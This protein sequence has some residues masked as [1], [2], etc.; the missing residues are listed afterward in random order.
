M[1]KLTRAQSVAA[2]MFKKQLD[3]IER[4]KKTGSQHSAA[5]SSSDSLS[6]KKSN[7]LWGANT[8]NEE[9][10]QDLRLVSWPTGISNLSLDRD[11]STKH[12]TLH[13]SSSRSILPN[14]LQSG[15]DIMHRLHI[16]APL[17]INPND[18]IQSM[19]HGTASHYLPIF[20]SSPTSK[21]H[22]TADS[23]VGDFTSILSPDRQFNA[24][25]P[26]VTE[27]ASYTRLETHIDINVEDEVDASD[28]HGP[29]LL[30]DATSS[31][32]AILDEFHAVPQNV[33][34]LPAV[35]NASVSVGS[36]TEQSALSRMSP[37]EYDEDAAM[38]TSL[39]ALAPNSEPSE[40]IPKSQ[41]IS[42]S[43]VHAES[44]NSLN[45]NSN[46]SQTFSNIASSESLLSVGQSPPKTRHKTRRPKPSPPGPPPRP[47]DSHSNL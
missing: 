40:N 4:L 18:I 19:V 34:N 29:A 28:Q 20:G 8:I 9:D 46:A 14:M 22:A 1:Q 6:A 42:R 43:A 12:N 36:V 24:L 3:E 26:L 27:S 35:A 10:V 44:P 23:N 11:S 30:V 32:A 16:D 37:K 2:A 41:E 17:L 15:K 5:S 47:V 45:I 7:G 38:T 25:T 13:E 33:R 21:A 31:F 39:S